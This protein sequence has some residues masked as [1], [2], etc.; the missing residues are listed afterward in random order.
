MQDE[1]A[2]LFVR[3]FFRS[4]SESRDFEVAF[5]A[6]EAAV[7]SK[8]RLVLEGARTRTVP[9]FELTAPGPEPSKP[10]PSGSFAAG[11]PA[12]L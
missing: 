3:G 4:L 2:Y 10:L 6:G 7:R 11:V 1:A 12:L 9:F 5:R 8:T